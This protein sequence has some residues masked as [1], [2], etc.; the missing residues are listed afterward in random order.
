MSQSGNPVA[1][2][3]HIRKTPLAGV[4]AKSV[5]YQFAKG[6]QIVPNPA[7]TALLRAGDLADRATFY[8][9]DLAFAENPRLPTNPHGF[10]ATIDIPGFRAITLGAQEQIATFF[11]TDG[12]A[13]IHPEPARFFEVP[14]SLPL[15][16]NLNYILLPGASGAAAPANIESVVINDG[17]A[18][19]SMVN[20]ITVTVDGAAV[21]DPGA[22]ELRRQDGS[23]VDA[24]LT[25]TLLGGKTVAVLTLLAVS[26]LAGG[27]A[28]GVPFEV[29]FDPNGV[30]GSV[31][32]QL[33]RAAG[34][35][36]LTTHEGVT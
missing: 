29:P 31:R 6:D 35:A 5:I 22:I 19:H 23:L 36:L 12:A 24:Q 10:L 26:N 1:Y 32:A 20:G 14:I 3:P 21:L 17:S 4:S 28:I 16:E 8:R 13:V 25:I 7:T 15:P 11:A 2:A 33:A 27:I 18:Q 34:V 9:H 30:H